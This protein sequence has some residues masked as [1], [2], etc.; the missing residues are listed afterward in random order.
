MVN[1]NVPKIEYPDRS[2][3][4]YGK[5]ILDKNSERIFGA[6]NKKRHSSIM[7]TLPFDAAEDKKLVYNLISHGMNIARINCAHDNEEIWEKTINNIRAAEKKLGLSCKVLMDIAGPKSRIIRLTSS[8]SNPVVNQGDS[9]LFTGSPV[10]NN[11]HGMDIVCEGGI[12]EVIPMLKIGDPV[13]IDDGTIECS[14]S[15]IV[16]DGVILEVNKVSDKKGIRMKA[17]K[18]LN[19]PNS[20]AMIS[21]LSAKDLGC[22]NPYYG[23]NRNHSGSG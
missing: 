21:T 17:E 8:L 20:N 18:G 6:L 3:F 16:N 5:E 2:S 23:E 12:P 22:G 10:I 7:V 9:F 11:F 15:K 4:F 19:F 1:G 13:L 14:V